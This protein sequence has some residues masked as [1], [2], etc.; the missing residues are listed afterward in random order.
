[1]RAMPFLMFQGEAAQAISLYS[2]VFSDFA[3]ESRQDGEDGRVGRAVISLGGQRL[4]IIDSPPVHDFGFT[5]AVSLFVDCDSESDVDRM[6][7][8]LG[9]GGTVLMPLDTYPFAARFGWVQDAF[10]VSWQ[11]N[12]AGD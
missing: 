2:E 9:E 3:E 7:A 11:L 1:M 5:P 4:T 8:A 12:F 6:F 10:G